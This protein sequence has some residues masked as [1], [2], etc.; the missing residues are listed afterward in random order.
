MGAVVLFRLVLLARSLPLLA[1]RA[2]RVHCLPRRNA[3]T[4]DLVQRAQ[5]FLHSATLLV[6]K[7]SRKALEKDLGG[8]LDVAQVKRVRNAQ[9]RQKAVL[10]NDQLRPGHRTILALHGLPHLL[11]GLGAPFLWEASNAVKCRARLKDICNE[12]V[13]FDIVRKANNRLL[14]EGLHQCRN[15]AK[16][17]V[18]RKGL[19]LA[20]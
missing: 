13:H 4:V 12:C 8:K 2:Q 11:D 9:E 17:V 14:T 19:E 18:G 5:A 10:V 20:L 7:R 1:S 15:L 3:V 6:C 16:L